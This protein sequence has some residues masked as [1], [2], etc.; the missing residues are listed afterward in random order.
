VKD[1]KEV[2]ETPF[3]VARTTVA[4][5]CLKT[6]HQWPLTSVKIK[7]GKSSVGSTTKVELT[8]V[9]DCQSSL[10]RLVTSIVY[11]SPLH[12]GL[13]CDSRR[14]GGGW[15]RSAYNGQSRWHLACIINL[16]VAALRCRAGGS[17]FC[18]N[19]QPW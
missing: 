8:T 15:N 10:H 9:A 18:E 14:S 13:F 4:L 5:A 3:L 12:S 1:F 17:I 16:S 19:G 11:K 6:I 2:F 7:T